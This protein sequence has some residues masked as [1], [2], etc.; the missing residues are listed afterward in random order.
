M[1][2]KG[3]KDQETAQRRESKSASGD[4]PQIDEI[5]KDRNRKISLAPLADPCRNETQNR[6]QNPSL[7]GEEE[8]REGGLR[9][10]RRLRSIPLISISIKE[11]GRGRTFFREY[12]LI[13]Q[14]IVRRSSIPRA[15]KVGEGKIE[16]DLF[17]SGR[18][19]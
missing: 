15:A 18:T 12:L 8:R 5:Q 16:D 13:H 11:G 10:G 14:P 7:G 4:R 1:R 3:G 2:P 19:K 9:D 6:H 17:I